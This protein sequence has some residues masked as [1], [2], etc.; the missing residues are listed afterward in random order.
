LAHSGAPNQAVSASAPCQTADF[1][2]K[3]GP[4]PSARKNTATAIGTAKNHASLRI[5]NLPS[6]VFPTNP[7]RKK[8]PQQLRVKSKC[9]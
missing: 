9:Q 4:L 8:R 2:K 3:I 7:V 1:L 5:L 6:S